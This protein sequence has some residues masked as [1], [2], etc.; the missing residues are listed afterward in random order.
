VTSAASCF[1]VAPAAASPAPMPARHLAVERSDADLVRA[2]LTTGDE[3][4]FGQIVRRYQ[5]RVFRV[6]VGLLGNEALADEIAQRVF[7]KA[8]FRLGQLRDPE[9]LYGW[10]LRIARTSALDE[11]KRPER[12]RR[13]DVDVYVSAERA[14]LPNHAVKNLVRRVLSELSFG[15]REILLLVD[16]ERRS[17]TETASHLGISVSA[18]KMRAKRARERFRRLYEE[19]SCLPGDCAPAPC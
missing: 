18:V 7:V 9:A 13:S 3:E 8:A 16:L 2:Y 6:L 1:A 17:T 15:D 12:T 14:T 11:L 5:P 19:H 4:P 10:L